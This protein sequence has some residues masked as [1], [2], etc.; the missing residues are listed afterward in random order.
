MQDND[1]DSSLPDSQYEDAYPDGKH[2]KYV[3]ENATDDVDHTDKIEYRF[4]LS[5]QLLWHHCQWQK[6]NGSEILPHPFRGHPGIKYDTIFYDAVHYFQLFVPDHL[7]SQFATATNQFMSEL[8]QHQNDNQENDNQQVIENLKQSWVPTNVNEMKKFI[9]LLFLM[10]IIEKPDVFLYWSP[11]PLYETPLFQAIMC[12]KRFILLLRC[13]RFHDD[14]H[15]LSED[16]SECDRLCNIR[17]LFNYFNTRFRYVYVAEQDIALHTL[18]IKVKRKQNSKETSPQEAV[19]NVKLHYLRESNSGYM[20]QFQV[21]NDDSETLNVNIFALPKETQNWSFGEKIALS[22]LRPFLDRGYNIYMDQYFTSV[23]L[24][25][26]LYH[27]KT[28]A[29]GTILPQ[30]LPPTI[31]TL[32]D[33]NQEEMAAYTSGPLLCLKWARQEP[34]CIL[35]S[36]HRE[37]M[38]QPISPEK[39][40][41]SKDAQNYDPKK[42]SALFHYDQNME[43]TSKQDLVG[44]LFDSILTGVHFPFF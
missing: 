11:E 3:K 34:L 7:M 17:P 36:L 30:N 15:G 24:F 9:G 43:N 20:F 31:V 14:Q 21:C 44:T 41:I 22:L 16:E 32:L 29:C 12:K 28:N 39:D 33:Q 19:V 25:N 18:T 26:Y 27:R 10:G 1:S 5:T 6:T 40:T 37:T 8:L 35:S 4:N 2:T 38:E 42:M 13:L 23:Q